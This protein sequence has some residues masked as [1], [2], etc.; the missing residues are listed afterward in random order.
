MDEHAV[1]IA[2]HPL[3]RALRRDAE[4]EVW[5][6]A[7]ASGAGVEV[8][9][10]LAGGEASLAREAEALLTLDHPHLVPILDVAVDAGTVLVRPLLQRNLADW[11]VQRQSPSPGEAVTALA[12]IAAALG[13]LHALS[14]SA[15]GCSAGDIRL[16]P[17]GAPLLMAEGARIET[18]RATDAWR[19][20]SE[21]VAADVAGWR[22]LALAVLEAAGAALPD[23]VEAALE[24]RQLASAGD[25]LLAAWPALPLEL[26]AAAPPL[27]D[28]RVRMRRRDRAVGV[29]A[30]WARL[31]L[32]AERLAE[33]G[34]PLAQRAL[35][36][37]SVVRPRFWAVAGGGAAA[38]TVMAVL[39]SQAGAA[40]AGALDAGGARTDAV[41]AAAPA[42]DAT[43]DAAPTSTAPTSAAPTT[44]APTAPAPADPGPAG[45]ATPTA[46]GDPVASAAALLAEREA[47]LDAGDAACLVALHDPG[48][49]QLTAAD[50][51]RMP[52]DGTV[53]LVQ[54]LGDAWLLRVVSEREP[55][56]V[57]VMSTEA[58][59]TLRDA[60]SD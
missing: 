10:S 22:Q 18:E 39:L 23:S 49:P 53:E 28:V 21:G 41:P 1:T 12:P 43:T 26:D 60:W 4:R 19:E 33:R 40:D 35:A 50:P 3:V 38:L 17:D 24:Q 45:T 13:A 11:L 59:W 7:D 51:W 20:S 34:G 36:A 42:S 56:S 14:A 47:C 5:V 55:A 52:D 15:G 37:L 46:E 9:R 2:A 30:V 6:A 31:A 8:H 16:D 48:S 58:G 44:M 29:D 25:A 32:L 27:A 54:R 57:L